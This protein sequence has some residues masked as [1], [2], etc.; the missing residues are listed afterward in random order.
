VQ[1][2]A[3]FLAVFFAIDRSNTIGREH[4]RLLF[5]HVLHI[6]K[7]FGELDNSCDD[8]ALVEQLLQSCWLWSI[9]KDTDSA[10]S[11][12]TH[13]VALNAASLPDD[14]FYSIPINQFS[15]W[16]LAVSCADHKPTVT[17]AFVLAVATVQRQFNRDVAPASPDERRRLRAEREADGSPSPPILKKASS[18]SPS[19]AQ[20]SPT[21]APRRLPPLSNIPVLFS[22]VATNETLT[23]D[24]AGVP[25]SQEESKPALV[26]SAVQMLNTQLATY[27]LATYLRA[28]F[29]GAF[30]LLRSMAANAHM[31][32]E[33]SKA[34][35]IAAASKRDPTIGVRAAGGLSASSATGS[36]VLLVPPDSKPHPLGRGKA[37]LSP[38]KSRG[39]VSHMPASGGHSGHVGLGLG[40]G[41]TAAM[42]WAR[43]ALCAESPWAAG[44]HAVVPPAVGAATAPPAAVAAARAAIHAAVAGHG[45]SH[46]VAVTTL[47]ASS[48]ALSPIADPASRRD[49]TERLAHHLHSSASAPAMART[50]PNGVGKRLGRSGFGHGTA[51]RKPGA[52]NKNR[53]AAHMSSLISVYGPARKGT[54]AYKATSTQNRRGPGMSYSER[55]SA[56]LEALRSNLEKAEAQLSV[57]EALV[58][59]EEAAAAAQKKLLRMQLL[60]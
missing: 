38:L 47:P 21:K 5:T 52:N 39:P 2:R 11:A 25:S 3:E 36:D 45:P 43:L 6:S 49:S 8:H 57:A 42:M 26:Q 35:A 22:K 27:L 37:L 12:G 54:A 4:L 55:Y 24:A 41:L 58:R 60:R 23:T 46:A 56:E 51:P 59:R 1:E 10:A 16:L 29:K 28:D 14:G 40:L 17:H 34:I 50:S 7:L 32:Q 13:S 48:E 19:S 15:S 9:S 20:L 18:P 44:K 33:A 30:G 53:V 31:K